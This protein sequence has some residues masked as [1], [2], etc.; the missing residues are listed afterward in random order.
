VGLG[1]AGLEQLAPVGGLVTLC[2]TGAAKKM[3]KQQ[4]AADT[5]IEDLQSVVHDAEALLKGTAGQVSRC[6]WDCC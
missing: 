1:F 6:C 3:S 5:L 4:V 2:A